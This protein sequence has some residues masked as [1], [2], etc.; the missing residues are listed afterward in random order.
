[1]TFTITESNLYLGIV[2]TLMAIQIY[3]QTRVEK[4]KKETQQLWSQIAIMATTFSM[5]LAAFEKEKQ[6]KEDKQ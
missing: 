2:L 5:Y 4:L 6:E 3:Q 1:M